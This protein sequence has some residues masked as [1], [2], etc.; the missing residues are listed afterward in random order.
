MYVVIFYGATF[1]GVFCLA[2]TFFGSERDVFGCFWFGCGGREGHVLR[3]G[4]THCTPT[5]VVLSIE[6]RSYDTYSPGYL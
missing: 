5:E 4:L 6:Q 1:R 2:C 3:E